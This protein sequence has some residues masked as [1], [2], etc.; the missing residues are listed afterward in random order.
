MLDEAVDARHALMVG[1]LKSYKLAT[2]EEFTK[3]TLGELSRYIEELEARVRAEGDDGSGFGFVPLGFG[4][5]G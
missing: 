2:G 3:H 4:G 5:A 1:G